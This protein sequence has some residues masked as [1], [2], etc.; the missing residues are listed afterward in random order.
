MSN[1]LMFQFTD[2]VVSLSS[3]ID[4]KG[5]A[6]EHCRNQ[7]VN[8]QVIVKASFLVEHFA[9]T[10]S[11]LSAEKAGAVAVIDLGSLN[12][13]R[14][15]QVNL[16][17]CRILVQNFDVAHC[18]INI[19]GRNLR[20]TKADLGRI[21]HVT[22]EGVDVELEGNTEDPQILDLKRRIF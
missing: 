17:L 11:F 4:V 2:T 10:M 8:G 22:N 12:S 18:C 15:T 19:H 9:M 20:I 6:T 5:V 7:E 3:G 13:L 14:C 16:Q 1:T 21:M